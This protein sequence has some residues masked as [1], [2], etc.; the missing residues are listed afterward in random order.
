MKNDIQMIEEAYVKMYR[1]GIDDG[2]ESQ[3]VNPHS[4]GDAFKGAT[5]TGIE[6]LGQDYDSQSGEKDGITILT[7]N[8]R[9]VISSSTDLA[10]EYSDGNSV[11]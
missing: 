2:E 9:I 4:E 10:I 11:W 8:G 5:I 7:D 3:V 6:R 1:E